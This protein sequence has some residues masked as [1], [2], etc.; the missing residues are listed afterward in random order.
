[1]K[2]L[3]IVNSL[4][5]G[6]AEKLV[7][8]LALKFNSLNIENS[9]LTLEKSD[10]Y[11]QEHLENHNKI[12]VNSLDAAN[13]YKPSLIRNIR[14]ILSNYDIIQVHLF[15]AS[16]WTALAKLTTLKR[17]TI[18][19]TE[20]NTTN[21]RRTKPGFKY[22]DKM[23]YSQFTR[24]IT[25]SD[26]VDLNL[27]NY[28]GKK[29]TK[30][31]KI[32]NGINIEAINTAKPYAKS[33]FGLINDQKIILQVSSFTP[34]KDQKTLIKSMTHLPKEFVLFL[35]GDGLLKNDCKKLVNE[36]NLNDRV[37]FLGVRNDVP[38]LLKTSDVI[39]LSSHYEGLSL[40]CIEGMA[41][42]RP[43]IASNTP[44]LGD[45][46]ENAGIVFEL[47]NHLELSNIIKKL[48]DSPKFYQNTI[49]NCINK[50]NLYNIDEMASKYID[51]YK[52]ILN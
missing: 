48:M 37:K 20:H 13:I 5:T 18:V 10:S 30:I 39:V 47:Q 9:V 51:L 40:S 26:A 12:N 11:L 29:F 36:L 46:V 50:A 44:G 28:L 7:V 22:L 17:H 45:I 3:Q 25:I 24:I 19:F 21:R 35:V 8:E 42:G 32:Y 23:I 14:S 49:K 41:S 33:D 34:Q 43:F 27:K 1:M 31:I 6:G 52:S 16:Y 15:P 4:H 2:I 38:R